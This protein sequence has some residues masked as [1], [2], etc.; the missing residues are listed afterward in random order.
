VTEPPRRQPPAR[1]VTPSLASRPWHV[2]VGSLTAGLAL[3]QAD[4]P[5][6]LGAA[7]AVLACLA[8]LRA[9]RLAVVA[10]ALLLAGSAVGDARLRALDQ[11][12]ALIADGRPISARAHLVTH[13]RPSRFGAS[14]E[15]RIATGSLAGTRVLLRFSERG[16]RPALPAST[17]IG[18]E[19]ALAGS[20][21]HPTNDPDATFDFAAHLRRR[22]IAG[23]LM[24]DKVRVTGRRRG[25]IAG[26]LDRLRERAERAVSAGLPDSHA[27]LALGMVLGED[28]QIDTATRDDWRDAGLSHLLAVSG[29]NVMLL[30]AL[31]LPLLVA[32]GLGPRGRGIALLCLVALYVPLAGAG[33]SL[34]RA[35][36]MGAA[37]IAAM[38]LSRPSSRWYS[39]LLAAAV[40]LALNPRACGDPGWQLSFIAVAGI[41]IAGRP[42]AAR[43]R[44][45]ARELAGPPSR[46]GPPARA[47]VDGLCEGIA[48]TVAATLATAPLLA[49]HFGSVP[50][51]GLAANLLAL[52]AVAPAM[53]LGMV[54]ASLG[55]VSPLLPGADRFAEALGPPARLA[56]GYLDG[57]AERCATLPG[58]RL[59]LPLNSAP[60]VVSA[61]A[62]LTALAYGPRAARRLAA[63]RTHMPVP[64]GSGALELAAAWR[65]SSRSLRNGAIALAAVLLVLGG[66]A[67]L[68]TPAP[69]EALTVRFLDIGQ[70]DATLIQDGAGAAA[71]FDG[72]PPEARVYRQLR[73]A[74]VR[75]L[76]LMVATHQSRDH[77]GGL[78]EVLERIPTSLLLENSDGTS[79]R[80]FRRLLAEADTR[81]IRHVAA[82]AGQ[83]L[84][85]GRLRIEILSP[86]P[87]PPG[88]P[89][90]E[91]PNPRGVAAIVS[92]GDFDLWLSADAESDAI[93]PLPLRRVEAMKV[94]H[95]GSADP[96][97][98]EVLERL[99]PEVAAIEVGAE[100]S[101]GHP[102]PETL[103]A[104]RAAVP[105]V[106]RTD[107][108]G[109]V[110]VSVQDG[111]MDVR[112]EH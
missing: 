30:I 6:A 23:E 48:I 16:S 75:R 108:D 31:A 4:A 24:V 36:V 99:Q 80:D 50:V 51:A 85:I 110:T 79:D 9:P 103:A 41:L 71:L 67:V 20:L 27:A 56:I 66:R 53:W 68:A 38:T 44:V 63:R 65:R 18:A 33:P 52:P 84:Q 22:G 37:G 14:A 60:A 39:L 95:H 29:Q 91:D 106:Y 111:R 102:T 73:A 82:R 86:V 15:A 3:A 88:T 94:S 42:L 1:H 11:A 34:Q 59:A 10:A 83:V 98:P 43:L 45:I 101:Y 40:T 77:Q 35:G 25:G 107:R 89:P 46:A 5:L 12:S 7:A 92:A 72:G 93:L 8:V 19:L 112:T 74:G 76:D 28:E 57:L 54:K 32:G 13:P 70:G 69:P 109:T 58:A 97:L 55:L 47:A 96:G 62:A 90:P 87:L 78:Q 17:A 104:L 2:A 21:R 81:G 105:H 26:A 100:N 61:Y 64:A 49:Y